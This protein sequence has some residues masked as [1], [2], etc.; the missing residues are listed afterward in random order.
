MYLLIRYPADII[1]EAV[2][3]AKG[4]NRMRVAAAGFPETL[5]LRRSGTQWFTETRQPVD[6]E[7]LM[8][9]A[10]MEGS[11]SSSQTVSVDA[12]TAI[13]QAVSLG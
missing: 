2:V 3:L 4:K 5:E 9:D 8:A 6:F 13:S 7:F 10:Q 11:V 12:P 1:I